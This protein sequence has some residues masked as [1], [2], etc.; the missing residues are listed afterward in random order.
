MPEGSWSAELVGT[1]VHHDAPY[2][3]PGL[4]RA[5][6]TRQPDA[7]ACEDAART[8][9]YAELDLLS[10]LVADR[11][12]K[13]TGGV[14]GPVVVS[15]P[16]GVDLVVA[17]L[18]V[19]KAG[20]WYLPVSEEEPAERIRA[21]VTAG[22]PL[23]RFGEAEPGHDAFGE[24]PRLSVPAEAPAGTAWRDLPEVAADQPVYLMFTSG[25][26]GTPKGVLLGSAAL[27]SRILWQNRTY[28]FT[29]EDRILQ[30]TPHTFDVSGWELY[31]PLTA[32]ARCV[33]LPPGDHRDPA[34]LAA[35]IRERAI[36]L[37]H[38]VPSMLSEF[39]RVVRSE[40]VGTVRRVFAS[41]EALPA[42]LVEPYYRV[43][44]APLTNLYGPT[45]TAI[46]VTAWTVPSTLS[47]GDTVR[48]GG[49]VDNTVLRVA[50][51][52]GRPVRGDEAGELW[53]AG[54]QVALGYAGL[55]ERTAQAF[56]TVDGRRWYRTGDRVRRL[57]GELEYLGRADHQVK[58][59]GVRIEPG[60]VERALTQHPSVGHAVVAVVTPSDGQAPELLAALTPADRR[61]PIADDMTLRAHLHT[62]VPPA[63]VPTAFHRP[64]SLP[65]LR[66]GKTD[67]N[68]VVNL[69]RTWWAEV[70]SVS[71]CGVDES[72]D[73]LAAIWWSS[74]P[75]NIHAD[76]TAGFL[77][78][79]GHSLLAIRM[80]G[81]IREE[82]GVQLPLPLLIRDN[83]SLDNIRSALLTATPTDPSDGPGTASAEGPA[84][85]VPL[86]AGQ[87]GLWL[88]NRLHGP[89]AAAYNVTGTLRLRGQVNVSALSA[90]VGDLVGRHQ[91]LRLFVTERT[92]DEPLLDEARGAALHLAVESAPGIIDASVEEEFVRRIAST[93]LPM[94]AAPLAAAALLHD[95]QSGEARLTISL[96]HLISDQ[97]TLDILL[98]DIADCY[99]ARV[100]G[101]VPTRRDH[102]DF[103]DHV[104]RTNAASGSASW[105]QDLKYWVE[106][107]DGAPVE[108]TLP[109][110]HGG[111]QPPT[112]VGRSTELHLDAADTARL[113]AFTRAHAVTPFTVF[114]TCL[115]IVLRG[116][117]GRD[118]MVL[119]MPVS[120]RRSADDARLAGFLLNTV[121]LRI[122]CRQDGQAADLLH[123]I[124]E[125]AADAM[126]HEA[127]GFEAI[128]RKLELPTRPTG[129]ALF[130]IWLNDLSH[131]APAPHFPGL[132]SELCHVPGHA[133]LFDVN[134][135]LRKKPQY[136]LE[137]TVA[138]DRVPQGL[139]DHILAQLKRV[140]TKL[141]EAPGTP[142]GS[143][144]LE[145]P[146]AK[147]PSPTDADPPV[148]NSHGT[149]TD[150]VP[151]RLGRHID[152]TPDGIA[153]ACDARAV[154]YAELAADAQKVAA[155]LSRAGVTAGA[156][157]ELRARRRVGLA[158]AL[159]G[160]WDMGAAPAIVDAALP[161]QLLTKYRTALAPAAVVEVTE[162]GEVV[163]TRPSP[164]GRPA[165][166]LP[167]RSHVL[168]TSGTSG[169]P[170]PV[171]VPHSAL[172]HNLAWYEEFLRPSAADRTALVGGLGHD[173]VLRDLLVPLC[174]GGTVVVPPDEA[175]HSP[176]A[177]F[178]FLQE[179][180]ITLLHAT[181][182]LLEVIASGH[183]ERP[184][185][186]LVAL[187]TVMS[188]GAP[189]TAGLARR[190]RGFTD[191][192]LINAY[193]TTETPQIASCQVIAEAGA[194][195][196]PSAPDESVFPFGLG[197]AGSEL[198]V[199]DEHGVPCAVGHRGEIVVRSPH[200]ALGYLD[201][202]RADDAFGGAEARSGT[203]HFRT[204]DLG[205]LD[206]W[207][208]IRLD[209]R[210]DRQVLVNGYRLG[211]EH[212]EA[213]ASRHHQ[214]RTALASMTRTAVG[215]A[216][217]LQVVPHDRERPP[218][219][220][221]IR[222]HLLSALPRHAVPTVIDVV[223]RLT[224]DRNHKTV[225]RRRTTPVPRSPRPRPAEDCS[226]QGES[227]LLTRLRGV[228]DAALGRP[229][230]VDANFFDAGLDSI[231][232][233]R[234]HKLLVQE[235]GRDLPVTA[236]F[237]HPNIRA[238]STQLS[239]DSATTR[240]VAVRPRGEVTSSTSTADRRRAI[241]AQLSQDRKRATR[242][243]Q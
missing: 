68:A 7:V 11:V 55:P 242:H 71:A 83:S 113:D 9:T 207:G 14:T 217:T 93:L 228:A 161:P 45:E 22:A 137:A 181:P 226:R 111:G 170:A 77:S 47:P 98:A 143:F 87:R 27:V 26:S 112:F 227:P 168:F 238:L 152:R 109:F 34:R 56:P 233:L 179:E 234:L 80:T 236:L 127:P 38:F 30:K 235:L 131:V 196:D 59:R 64:G 135:Y 186:R 19:L 90:A 241:R 194:P 195:I 157:V 100:S 141:L 138:T 166:I 208:G 201:D 76:E 156:A 187:R 178:D 21:I 120:R 66:S 102:S 153:L 174:T 49:P 82:L 35:F 147:V 123:H 23:A 15:L 20:C 17:I 86:T 164:D 89:A 95:E 44:T 52:Q 154:S 205:R 213:A 1:H 10:D 116:W 130:Q 85:P 160:S 51:E 106:L 149:A 61:E 3:L 126:A 211:L 183:D 107:L 118:S 110:R 42:A 103:L 125:R 60:E 104:R 13:A 163:V 191:A 204:G 216:L 54:V 96:H 237:S 2:G 84:G 230:D 144:R 79:G 220:A 206:P 129:N 189:L 215:D 176:T 139:A 202:T 74:L 151:E 177:L 214:V 63:Y 53:I 167:E 81:R 162:T 67:R 223:T 142:L 101:E 209:G 185:R 136:A 78:L 115:A 57:G 240:E 128:L 62:L 70:T 150:G 5:V 188:G 43:F 91:S 33:L 134:F 8:L 31:C 145:E 121:P 58:I 148:P 219:G 229:M 193:G 210:R 99:A 28:G 94:D 140:L 146:E 158:A 155:A 124:R 192:R 190:V 119:G 25:S 105:H 29:P 122:D 24:L 69:L 221:D 200:L 222:R 114:A 108:S 173:P 218:T 133:A 239:D 159:L 232:L 50:D 212:I 12:L 32:G 224:T 4:I 40:D 225:A 169:R 117:L 97:Q 184:G 92:D 171:L 37:V 16:R 39:L 199:V 180:E 203:R 73:P 88:L 172:A 18:G 198:L 65:L 46:D 175:L 132:E 36:T 197:V 41:G 243:G 48:I 165:R 72:A 182:A 75:G 6:R 231:T